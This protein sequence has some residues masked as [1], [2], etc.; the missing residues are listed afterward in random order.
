MFCGERSCLPERS[1]LRSKNN[2]SYK[3]LHT[4][5]L[6]SKKHPCKPFKAALTPKSN[7]PEI[8]SYREGLPEEIAPGKFAP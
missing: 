3:I 8:L 7:Q 4:K 5:M 1:T 6:H 2:N